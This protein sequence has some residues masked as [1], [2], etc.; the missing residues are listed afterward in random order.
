MVSIE[1]AN[2]DMV[3]A[4]LLGV[5]LNRS[6]EVASAIYFSPRAA[7]VRLQIISDVAAV[8]SERHASE[9]RLARHMCD[10]ARKIIDKR[11]AYIHH[12]WGVSKENG[13][14]GLGAMPLRD[15]SFRPIP[16]EDL[17]QVVS[18]LRTLIE[19]IRNSLGKIHSGIWT[20]PSSSKIAPE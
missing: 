14:V 5:L 9:T 3:L 4:D 11:H 8:M 1:M 10:R 7:T 2:L 18:D 16:I 13:E 12:A 15:K 17:E 6:Q 19:E 20:P